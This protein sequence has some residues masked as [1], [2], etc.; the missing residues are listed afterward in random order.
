MSAGTRD[1]AMCADPG[2][3]APLLC[4]VI[5]Y[6]SHSSSCSS[7]T[8]ANGDCDSRRCNPSSSAPAFCP[9]Q[10][11][12]RNGTVAASNLSFVIGHS[13]V[14]ARVS[15]TPFQH[16]QLVPRPRPDPSYQPDKKQAGSV[17]RP[18]AILPR[19]HRRTAILLRPHLFGQKGWHPQPSHP[20]ADVR[21]LPDSLSRTM[22]RNGSPSLPVEPGRWLPGFSI[23][24]EA[25][26]LHP[27]ES[28]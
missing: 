18:A 12:R 4:R 13:A 1:V 7:S 23:A 19:F 15:S 26:L 3:D 24:S 10:N 14:S 25:K 17:S 11:R 20:T 9:E 22:C 8:D 21:M 28:E 2:L 16:S 6:R 5:G 27:V